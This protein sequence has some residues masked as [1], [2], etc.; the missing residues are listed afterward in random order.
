ME[1]VKYVIDNDHAHERAQ[2][3]Q[4]NTTKVI[5]I[6]IDINKLTDQDKDR[7]VI[8]HRPYCDREVGKLS[9]WN[10]KYVFV[11]FKGPFGEACLPEDISFE[12]N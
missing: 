1:G 6:M 4:T 8:Y 2:M 11:R 12:F 10:D 9:S 5:P 3:K 7:G